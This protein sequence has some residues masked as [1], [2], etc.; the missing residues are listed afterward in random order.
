MVAEYMPGQSG[1]EQGKDPEQ[2]SVLRAQD[3]GFYETLQQKT[4]PGTSGPGR[5]QTREKPGR[6]SDPGSDSEVKSQGPAYIFEYQVGAFKRRS[7]AEVLQQGLTEQGFAAQ[8]VR[9]TVQGT[10]WFRVLVTY[11]G[12][13]TET[14]AFTSRLRQAGVKNFFLRSKKAK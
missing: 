11:R 1:Q 7:Q 9:S 5:S 14:E 8:V 13:T 10:A 6:E 12:Q 2:S 3:L 4:T